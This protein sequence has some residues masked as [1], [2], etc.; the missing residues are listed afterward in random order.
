MLNT[1]EQFSNSKQAS[2]GYLLDTHHYFI[3]QPFDQEQFIKRYSTESVVPGG[4]CFGLC[5]HYVKQ[6]HE[7]LNTQCT[8]S[9][10]SKWESPACYDQCLTYQQSAQRYSLATIRFLFV[11][12][13][14]RQ[15]SPP[16]TID[17]SQ[18]SNN[19]SPL[20]KFLARNDEVATV[21]CL[22]LFLSNDTGRNPS[23]EG[24]VICLTSSKGRISIFDPNC[25]ILSFVYEFAQ[26]KR[27]ASHDLKEFVVSH[28]DSMQYAIVDNLEYK[29]SNS[30]EGMM[31][32]EHN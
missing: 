31:A 17:K 7:E 1:F 32:R 8:S 29:L 10:V 14:L 3:H 25:G 30:R 4:I 9:M 16:L 24:H 11:R 18:M 20:S 22:F 21:R 13:R 6:L 2:N 15:S 12:H 23:E 26:H 5:L 27:L 19:T 28:L